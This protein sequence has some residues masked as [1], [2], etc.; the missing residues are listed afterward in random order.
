MTFLED[1]FKKE[2]LIPRIISLLVAC[3]LWVYVMTDQNP[4][5]ERNYDVPLQYRNLQE[6]MVVFN[7]PDTV[8]VRVRAARTLL[9]D[10][11]VKYISAGIDLQ[12]VGVGEKCL[13]VI[14]GFANGEVV[15]VNPHDVVV[16][17]DTISEKRVP[18]ETRVVGNT[19][20]DLTISSNG[21][22]PAQVVVK[23]ATHR[24]A[25][26]SSVVAS[27]DIA[28]QRENFSTESTLVAVNAEGYDVPNV[29]ITPGKVT[30]DAVIVR[31]LIS[32]DLPVKVNMS[33]TLPDEVKIKQIEVLPKTVRVTAPPSFVKHLQ[34]IGTKP[35]DVSTL[36]GSTVKNVELSLPDKI[37]QEVKNVEVRF[38]VERQ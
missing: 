38:S 11:G 9:N 6:N 13:P 17:A 24:I 25:D 30:V 16:Y 22:N 32:V 15:S 3:G 10:E 4:I 1:L 5:V 35:V 2:N 37:V 34:E 36:N 21:I 29:T 33:G 7:A 20:D 26:I 31:K 14:A 8:T 18:V 23:G 12:N 27:I 19:D 28:N